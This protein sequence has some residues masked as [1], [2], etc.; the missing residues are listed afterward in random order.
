MSKRQQKN[1]YVSNSL[2]N[3]HVYLTSFLKKKQMSR[4]KS[5]LAASKVQLAE[6]GSLIAGFNFSAEGTALV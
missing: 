1:I 3:L 5:L 6:S 4:I 2:Y